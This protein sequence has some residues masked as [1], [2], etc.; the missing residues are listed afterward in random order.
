MHTVERIMLVKGP[1]RAVF[2][3]VSLVTGPTIITA[4]GEMILKKGRSIERRVMS[5]PCMVSR[6][7]AHN[8]KCCADILWASSWRRKLRVKTIE[9]LTKISVVIS[10]WLLLAAWGMKDKPTPMTRSAPRA[11][12]LSSVVLNQKTLAVGLGR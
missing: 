9:R 6:N 4:P 5:A 7:S 12:C 3:A 10:C 1:E 2:P 11:R 8:P